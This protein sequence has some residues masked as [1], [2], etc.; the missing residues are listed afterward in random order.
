M[1][2]DGRGNMSLFW[3]S[4]FFA[5]IIIASIFAPKEEVKT[6]PINCECSNK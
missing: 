6:N 1:I 4:V 3:V 2:E 5:L